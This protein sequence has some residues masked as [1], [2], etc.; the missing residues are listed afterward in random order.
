MVII[1]KFKHCEVIQ[2]DPGRYRIMSMNNICLFEHASPVAAMEYA[3][4]FDHHHFS[5]AG[6]LKPDPFARRR[7]RLCY[8]CAED[9]GEFYCTMNCGYP[10]TNG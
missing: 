3:E 7:E 10:E 2:D 5:V 6:A 4:W 9:H 8:D 1:Q